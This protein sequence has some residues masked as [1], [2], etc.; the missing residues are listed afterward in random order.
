MGSAVSFAATAGTGACSATPAYDWDFGD[1]S[2]HSA[3]QN[4]THTYATAGPRTWTLTVT[5]EA[6]TCSQSQAI[7]I[8]VPPA[9]TAMKKLTPFGIK[10]SGTNFQNGIAV[11]INGTEWT[12]AQW[13]SATKVKI[14]GG[15][16]L[17]AVVPKGVSTTFRFLNPDGG[18]V[19]TTWSW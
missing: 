19:T 18:E 10:V 3:L 1:G 12:N 15:N 14:S 13:K 17:K 4:P 6:A 16:S 7:S 8:V 5:A 2:A 11:S 9:V